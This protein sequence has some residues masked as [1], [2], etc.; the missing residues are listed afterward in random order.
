MIKFYHCEETECDCHRQE[1]LKWNEACQIIQNGIKNSDTTHLHFHPGT[2]IDSRPQSVAEGY[3]TICFTIHMD[4]LTVRHLKT[5]APSYTTVGFQIHNLKSKTK[6][7]EY[8]LRSLFLPSDAKIWTL[9]HKLT[10]IAR[11]LKAMEKGI[12][13]PVPGQPGKFQIVRFV[14]LGV[15]ADGREIDKLNGRMALHGFCG[16]QLMRENHRYSNSSIG[17]KDLPAFTSQ[18]YITNT[19]CF[20]HENCELCFVIRLTC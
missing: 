14:C 10:I 20:H 4:D 7:H 12:P 18:R 9:E 17:G 5:Q 16:A 11:D 2:K 15:L 13:I 6:R 3:K 1:T 8:F 19:V